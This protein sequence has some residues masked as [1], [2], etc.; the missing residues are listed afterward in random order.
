MPVV[1]WPASEDDEMGSESDSFHSDTSDS[2]D[3]EAEAAA[4]AAAAAALADP[5]GAS[6]SAAD[7]GKE[8]PKATEI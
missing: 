7:G 4:R 5:S 6:S 3:Y 2:R 8:K 1:L